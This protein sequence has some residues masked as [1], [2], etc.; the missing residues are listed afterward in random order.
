MSSPSDPEGKQLL[1]SIEK[2]TG[3]SLAAPQHLTP[4]EK[5]TLNDLDKEY[6]HPIP[7]NREDE[8]FEK[9]LRSLESKRNV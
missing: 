2:S 3:S 8:E 9:Y 5:E 1:N 7:E 4:E 6:S